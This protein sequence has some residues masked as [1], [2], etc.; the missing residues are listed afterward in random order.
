MKQ[1]HCKLAVVLDE[2]GGIEGVVTLQDLAEAIVG[3]MEADDDIPV[4]TGDFNRWQISGNVALSDLED[5]TGIRTGC[6]ADTVTG[7]ITEKT[8]HVLRPGDE[9]KLDEGRYTLRVETVKDHV[10]EQGELIRVHTDN[11]AVSA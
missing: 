11:P 3:V 7:L 10:L 4:V 9:V 2:Y 1:A 6:D 5:I 8:G